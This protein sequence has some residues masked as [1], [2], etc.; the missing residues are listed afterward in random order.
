MKRE[1]AEGRRRKFSGPPP[2]SHQIFIGNLPNNIS[3]ADVRNLFQGK[4]CS[5]Y[6]LC[7]QLVMNLLM[8][9][10]DFESW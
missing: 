2:D 3:E 4:L 7:Y 6:I 8:A 1:T 5:I 10:V 9:S